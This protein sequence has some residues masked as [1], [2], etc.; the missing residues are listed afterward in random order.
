MRTQTSRSTERID[1][2]LSKLLAGKR[3]PRRVRPAREAH[4]RLVAL[5]R[6]QGL[7][8]PLVIRP[9]GSKPGSYLVIAGNR[10]LA[11]L[12]EI[13]RGDGDPKIA[14]VLKDVDDPTA[15][16]YALGE[17]FGREPMHP[18]DEAEAFARL[19]SHDGKDADAIASE[20]GVTARY[21]RQ[22][23]KLASLTADVKAAYR[24]DAIDT[25]TAEAFASAPPDRQKVIWQEVCNRSPHALHAQHV[26]NVIAGEWIKAE[27]ALF[28]VL[29]L[30]PSAVSQDLFSD[31]V[32]VE[33]SAF[34]EAQTRALEA[35][36]TKLTEDGW[37]EVVVAKYDDASDRLRAMEMPEREY[38]A[39]T[40]ARLQKLDERWSKLELRAE[41]LAED[42]EAGREKLERKFEE[43]EAEQRELEQ[44]AQVV[45]SE[46]TKSAATVFLLCLPD[47]QV[48]REVRV[49]RRSR[50]VG[51][52]ADR[53]SRGGDGAGSTPGTPAPSSNEL[54]ER[55]TAMAFAHEAI[56]VRS[57]LLEDRKVLRRVLAL[58]LS[59]G[60]RG[61][62]GLAIRRDANAVTL[63]AEQDDFKSSAFDRLRKLRAEHDPFVDESFVLEVDAL[64]KLAKLK[65]DKL[66]AL[67]ELLVVECLTANLARPTPLIRL[68]AGELQV[69]V[70]QTWTPDGHWLSGYTKAQLAHLL[71]E[72][73]GSMHAPSPDRKKSDL[74]VQLATLFEQARDGKLEDAALAV[75]VN[76]WLPLAL[77]AVEQ[78]GSE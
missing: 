64:P 66:D 15:D 28:D 13:H 22:R 39:D 37:R 52:T 45:Y 31:Q 68:L 74:V 4:H 51:D 19:A 1:V 60:V 34:V 35:E 32:L 14:C 47:G 46:S 78:E 8:Q 23:M 6:S 49:P 42:D 50:R 41:A 43:I 59:G 16:A 69:D 71:V 17:N 62:D 75:R 25:A 29:A 70:R 40:D 18:L 11:A 72:L 3:N 77:R 10:R 61:S 33:R 20:F 56:A 65:D 30:P 7:L 36:R 12:K 73:K 63:A 26:R 9:A 24:D 53:S 27:H 76:R 54:S 21:V 38:D 2:P 48:R 5:I 58:V 57:A 67:I 44:S 55:Q